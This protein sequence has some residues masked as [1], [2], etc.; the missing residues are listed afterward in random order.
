MGTSK[1]YH[2]IPIDRNNTVKDEPAPVIQ[3]FI[4]IVH[5]LDLQ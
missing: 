1:S 5:Y 4:E 3:P 2:I